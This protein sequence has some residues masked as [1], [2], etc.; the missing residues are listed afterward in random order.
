MAI[1]FTSVA[2]IILQVTRTKITREKRQ[3]EK[4]THQKN[5]EMNNFVITKSESI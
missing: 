1:K 2:Y 4:R 3:Q 5:K